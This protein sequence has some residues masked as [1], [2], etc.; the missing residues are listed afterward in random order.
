M[1]ET[2]TSSSLG[3]SCMTSPGVSSGRAVSWRD[4]MMWPSQG[5]SRWPAYLLMARCSVVVPSASESHV[6]LGR[7]RGGTGRPNLNNGAGLHPILAGGHD[8]VALRE[9][10]GDHRNRA[11]IMPDRDRAHLD[12]AVGLDDVSE[13]TIGSAL[14]R[15]GRHRQNVVLGLQEQPDID[16]LPGPERVAWVGERCL[17]ADRAG[18]LIDLIVDQQQRPSIELGLAVTRSRRD[19]DGPL[20]HRLRD[21]LEIVLRQGEHNRDR[22]KLGHHDDTGGVGGVHDVARRPAGCR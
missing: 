19:R 8:A 10:A 7:R 15:R 5:D 18:R 3:D 6:L 22:L 11:G 13:Q 14:D 21:R 1:P 4:T 17:E 12:G 9:P 16:E 20:R 2:S